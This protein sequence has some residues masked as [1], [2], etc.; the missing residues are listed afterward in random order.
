[1]PTRRNAPT[2]TVRA[3]RVFAGA[4]S[5][6][7]AA[8]LAACADA[9]TAAPDTPLGRPQLEIVDPA[10]K[11]RV[12]TRVSPLAGLHKAIAIVGPAGGTF[13]LP[14][15]G[16]TVVVPEGAVKRPT[17]ITVTAPQGPG[18]WYDFG[19][20]GTK[21]AVPITVTQD[22]RGTNFNALPATATLEAGYFVDGTLDDLT[23]TALVKEF[24]PVTVN[25]TRTALSFQVSHF[26]GYMVSWGRSVSFE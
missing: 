24:L 7:T 18:V 4:A 17:S 19:P 3:R 11:A 23:G 25:S 21:F 9:P 2:L 10:V 22:L 15:V 1:M 16:I 6:I 26:S 13:S 14:S 8:V 5:I 12:L 20:S